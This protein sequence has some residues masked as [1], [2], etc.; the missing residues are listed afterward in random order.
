M[1]TG[2]PA[3]LLVGCGRAVSCSLDVTGV[4]TPC[5]RVHSFAT[6]RTANL[7]MAASISVAEDMVSWLEAEENLHQ[8]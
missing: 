1:T 7:T 2:Q 3:A 6:D 8:V 4:G 5:H